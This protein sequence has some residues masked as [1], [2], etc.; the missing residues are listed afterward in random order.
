MRKALGDT[1][2]MSR[3]LKSASRVTA[4]C[5]NTTTGALLFPGI[6]RSHWLG[7]FHALELHNSKDR[8]QRVW[9]L[10]SRAKLSI[11]AQLVLVQ[12]GRHFNDVM[13]LKL[14]DL[15]ERCEHAFW[16]DLQNL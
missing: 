4:E 10:V 16:N 8:S 2:E 13:G 12:A 3:A 9:H 15:Q 14:Y 11:V 6:G 5:R 1:R 7:M